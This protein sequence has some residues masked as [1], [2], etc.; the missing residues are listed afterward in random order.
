MLRFLEKNRIS[1]KFINKNLI[2]MLTGGLSN[3]NFNSKIRILKEE[4]QAFKENKIKFN[5][6]YYIINKL[7]KVKEFL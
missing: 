6:T 4:F 2:K 3:A 7:F 5:K 1:S